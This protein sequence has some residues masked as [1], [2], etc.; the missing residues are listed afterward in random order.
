VVTTETLIS[1]FHYI[2]SAHPPSLIL[3]TGATCHPMAVRGTPTWSF[4]SSGTV[5][6]HLHHAFLV[7]IF[8]FPLRSLPFFFNSAHDCRGLSK[9][10]PT[11][12]CI[13]L[14]IGT[15]NS[16]DELSVVCLA[17]FAGSSYLQY[18]VELFP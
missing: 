9:H 1:A 11:W 14:R 3:C 15:A 5:F 17:A 16:S 6:L 7:T 2:L 8:S 10:R 4:I 13:R 18:K 12:I